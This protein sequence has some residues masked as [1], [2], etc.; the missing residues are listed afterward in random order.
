MT[1]QVVKP[2]LGK[3]PKNVPGLKKKRVQRLFTKK[4]EAMYPHARWLN[5]KIRS[6]KWGKERTALLKY[7]KANGEQVERKVKPMGAKGSVLIAHDFHRNAVR[8]F[9]LDR[10]QH[11][12]KSAFF[13]GFEKRGSSWL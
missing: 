12:E 8:S 13:A 6:N 10:I 4:D 5:R 2:V 11:M 3:Q 9:R 7:T 1:K